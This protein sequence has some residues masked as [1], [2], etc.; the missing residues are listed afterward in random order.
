MAE[1]NE[2]NA[3]YRDT[4]AVEEV[5]EINEVG[6]T[7][8]EHIVTEPDSD[9]VVYVDFVTFTGKQK[10]GAKRVAIKA[11]EV[12]SILKEEKKGTVQ[13]SMFE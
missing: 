10:K 6:D 3:V 7:T 13:F 11:E 8:E 12:A 1:L 2:K 4:D 9:R 5:E